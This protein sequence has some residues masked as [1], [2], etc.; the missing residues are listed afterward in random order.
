MTKAADGPR[1]RKA[2]PTKQITE[3][4]SPARSREIA[5]PREDVAQPGK[6]LADRASTVLRKWYHGDPGSHAP[7][8]ARLGGELR[9]AS[10]V[11]S[12]L[13][14]S[15]VD[16]VISSGLMEPDVVYTLVIPR[17]TLADRKQKEKSLSPEQS[18]RLS[19]VLRIYSRAEEAI[20]DVSR[21]HRWLHRANRSLEGNRPIDLLGTDAGSR[22]V[23]KVLGRIEH[24]V[25]S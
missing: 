9:I 18:D 1:K 19:R 10:R 23:E 12:G 8:T 16:D 7:S 5:S 15:A 25:I 22:A 13:P 17:R 6:F 3:R 11:A 4:K 20:G 24:G 14:T 21:A 2:L